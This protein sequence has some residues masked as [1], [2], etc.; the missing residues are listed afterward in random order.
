MDPLA[1]YLAPP[2]NEEELAALA[3]SLRD[4]ENAADIFALSSV[5]AYS[6][7]A[8][9][10]QAAVQNEAERAGVLKNTLEARRNQNEQNQ[11][12]RDLENAR[13]IETR[14][15][16]ALAE[17]QFSQSQQEERDKDMGLEMDPVPY[18][19]PEGEKGYARVN[20]G[21]WVDSRTDLAIPPGSMLEDGKGGSGSGG[22][23]DLAS[24]KVNEYRDPEGNIHRVVMT[25]SGPIDAVTREPVTDMEGWRKHTAKSETAIDRQ[26]A[27]LAGDTTQLTELAT[28]VNQAVEVLRPYTRGG[29]LESAQED[30]PGAGRLSGKEGVIGKTGRLWEELK[31]QDSHNVYAAMANLKH[32][33]SVAGAG[34]SQTRTEMEKINAK[35]GT[36]PLDDPRAFFLSFDR[37]QEKLYNDIKAIQ[38]GAPADVLDEYNAQ[39]AEMPDAMNIYKWAPQPLDWNQDAAG[40]TNT[41]APLMQSN[42]IQEELDALDAEEAEIKARMNP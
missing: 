13:L 14:R 29:P 6:K 8:E 15:A 36:A 19:T 7:M 1:G 33:I 11:L 35:T 10:E 12:G 26:R 18:T 31:G 42:K 40:P 38:A 24:L 23:S 4:R 9:T 28:A 22:T 41:W 16:N 37:I 21:T 5:P 39:M 32:I 30:V 17:Q 34:L 27:K 3:A 20:Q 2:T 25:R